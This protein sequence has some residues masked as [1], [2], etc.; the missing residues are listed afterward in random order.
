MTELLVIKKENEKLKFKVTEKQLNR[1]NPNKYEKIITNRD[2][3]L[4]AYLFYDL[5]NMG[6][7]IEKA[8]EKFKRFLNEPDLFF[9]K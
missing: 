5:Y 4:L 2:Y 3:N 1:W 9:L 7:P 8:I 6:Y